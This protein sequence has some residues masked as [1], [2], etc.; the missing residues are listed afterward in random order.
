MVTL[1]NEQN[2][3][4]NEK[5]LQQDAQRILEYLGYPEF[6]LGI[7]LC[8]SNTMHQYNKQYRN[9]DKPTDILSFPY[10]PNLKAGEK[11]KPTTPEEK[12]LG[13]IILCPEYIQ[14]DLARWNQPFDVRMQQ[15]LVHGI[16]HLLGYDH[17]KDVD[18]EI[19]KQKEEEILNHLK[20]HTSN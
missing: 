19:M 8:D 15:L 16:C 17:I 1:K 18:Y 13:D 11:I 6:D 5:T 7:L 10:Y 4:I 3:S 14:E 2:K 9:K 12:N 20:S